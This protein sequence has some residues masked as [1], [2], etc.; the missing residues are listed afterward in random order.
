[1]NDQAVS[2]DG[3]VGSAHP[4]DVHFVN[5]EIFRYERKETVFDYEV[6][7]GV[8]FRG[9]KGW[10]FDEE[11][12][13]DTENPESLHLIHSGLCHPRV[14]KPSSNLVVIEDIALKLRNV[15]NVKLLPIEFS[16]V[17]AVSMY[18]KRQDLLD[19]Y[20]D[21]AV[22]L[23]SLP[24]DPRLRAEMPKY[25]EVLS[26]RLHTIWDKYDTVSIEY[27]FSVPKE[28]IKICAKMFEDYPVIN[29][30]GTLLAPSVANIIVPELDQRFFVVQKF[31]IPE[32]DKRG[33]QKVS[34]TVK[35]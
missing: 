35:T 8:A 16:K 28:I 22:F 10:P 34:G 9:G 5:T 30:S 3:S 15:P 20:E 17:V 25:Y 4:L 31:R 1:M 6:F 11:V 29:R 24:D 13:V 18:D 27:P 21:K 12:W 23:N 2:R 33:G 7:N 32:A 26:A 14:M 19:V